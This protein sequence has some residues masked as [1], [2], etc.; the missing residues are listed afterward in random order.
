MFFFISFVNAMKKLPKDMKKNMKLLYFLIKQFHPHMIISDFEFFSNIIA[1]IMGIPTIS[2]GNHHVQ[3][4]TRVKVSAR[5]MKDRVASFGV[6]RA[7]A[8]RPKKYLVTTFFYPPVKNPKRTWLF[9]PILRDEILKL[10]P[11]IKKHVL[12]YQTSD[13]Y[14]ALIPELQKLSDIKF[15]VYGMNKEK[16]DKN[17][18]YRKFNETKF[19]REFADAYAVIT[20]GGFTLM[21]EAVHLGKPVLSVPVKKQFEQILN[22]TYLERLGFGEFHEEI[23]A[24]IIASF[25]ANANIYRANLKK[26]YKPEDN[27]KILRAIDTLIERYSKKYKKIK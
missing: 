19:M 8:T 27:S 16:K 14:G 24:D 18:Q 13:S 4:K 23:D 15:I 6:I 10:K 17:I 22:A 3:T 25:L 9:P 5:Y 1:K 21:G 7:F 20:N 2:I 12:V 26:K 11:K